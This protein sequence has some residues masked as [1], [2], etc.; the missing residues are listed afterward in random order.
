MR[1]LIMWNLVTLDG[2]FV[3]GTNWD[4]SFHELVWGKELEDFS[5]TQLKSA[6]MLVFSK[7]MEICMCLGALTS[8]NL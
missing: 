3:G 7:T 1:N 2:Y 8:L 6:D 5:L 4:L